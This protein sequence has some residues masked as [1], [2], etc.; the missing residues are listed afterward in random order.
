MK[1]KKNVQLLACGF[2][3]L[4]YVVG[5]IGL[6]IPKLNWLFQN[7]IVWNLLLSAYIAFAFH[8]GGSYMFL[9]RCALVYIIAYS[10]E[11]IGVK[12]GMVFGRYHYGDDLGFKLDGVPAMIGLNWLVLIYGAA[13]LV[14]RL[15]LPWVVS[16][17]IGSACIT[18][19]NFF[20]QGFAVKHQLWTYD[21]GT[22]PVQNYIA[23][24]V[25]AFVLFLMLK[26]KTKHHINFVAV[27]LYLLQTAFFIALYIFG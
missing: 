26:L 6:C 24:F 1:S 7:L 4:I 19:T 20:M 25:L 12:T 13:N 27:Y 15:G 2:L 16:S 18:I 10:A 9:V 17:L 14:A 8:K 3:T 11:W 23:C 21:N 5:G 22:V